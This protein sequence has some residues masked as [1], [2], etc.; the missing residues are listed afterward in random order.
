MLAVFIGLGDIRVHPEL[1]GTVLT[2]MKTILEVTG[3]KMILI[4]YLE[5]VCQQAG[6]EMGVEGEG[7]VMETKRD[8]SQCL[9][10]AIQT[11]ATFD[12]GVLVMPSST[13]TPTPGMTT[14]TARQQRGFRLV[15]NDIEELRSQHAH[16]LRRL[17]SANLWTLA[18]GLTVFSSDYLE[19]ML[20]YQQCYPERCDYA[21]M[22]G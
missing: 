18:A 10:K 9:E 15:N 21:S 14:A 2:A 16:S 3:V 8:R 12:N 1:V 11:I 19:L 13:S 7:E 6:G 20:H 17:L 5:D 4:D 22:V